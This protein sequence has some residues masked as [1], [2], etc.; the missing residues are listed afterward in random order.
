MKKLRKIGLLTTAIVLAAALSAMTAWA[1]TKT[2]ETAVI[3]EGNNIYA[4]G[5]PILI[6][7]D[8]D[9][10]AYVYDQAGTG[11]L[12]FLPDEVTGLT[13]YGGGKN[14]PVNGDT[15]IIVDNV[16]MGYI[17]GG[18][19]SDGSGSADVSGDSTVLIKGNVDAATIYGGG[20]A[21]AARGNA[22]ANVGGTASAK[23]IADPTGNHGNIYGGGYATA[24]TYLWCFGEPQAHPM[25]RQK[26]GPTSLPAAAA[27]HTRREKGNAQADIQGSI[28]VQ[29]DAVDIRE[30]YGGGYASGINASAK[31]GSVK[32]MGSGN[33]MMIFRAGGD[34]DKGKADVAGAIQIELKNF[35]NLYGYTCGGG[36]ARNGGSA[37]AGSVE[38]GHSRQRYA[39]RRA[40]HGLLGMCCFLRRRRCGSRIFRLI[41]WERLP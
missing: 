17:Y 8:S 20:R 32:V 26:G 21:D 11:K 40:I 23:I 16:K 25:P 28:A 2:P 33:E 36:S 41:F 14:V 15:S 9:N 12:C 29:L 30:V 22:S 35:S 7:K 13:V 39:S 27:W 38:H 10:K 4:N 37:N 18:G 3:K 24:N 1:D 6:Q 5:V 31:A 19:Y 34:A